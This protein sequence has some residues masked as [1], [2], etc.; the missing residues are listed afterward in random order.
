MAHAGQLVRTATSTLE[1]L[2]TRHES[3]GARHEMRATYDPGAPFPPEHL[4][5]HQTEE[6]TVEEGALLFRV[7]GEERRLEAGHTIS[8]L[9]GTVHTICNPDEQRRAV[10]RW[11]TRPALRTGEFFEALAEAAGDGPRLLEVLADHTDEFRL[12][13]PD[14]R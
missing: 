2:V 10:A 13:P 12:A 3:G 14:G 8:I 5:P 7:E 6:F 4:H 11:G 1:Y 9:A